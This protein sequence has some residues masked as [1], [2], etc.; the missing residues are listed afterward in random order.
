MEA[1]MNRGRLKAAEKMFLAKYPGGFNNPEMEAV[2]KKHRMEKMKAMALDFF[3]PDNFDNPEDMAV[4]MV[5]IV[6]SSS[7]V[8]VFEK[9]RFRDMMKEIP[10]E[11]KYILVSGLRLFIHGKNRDDRRTGF[12]MMTDLLSVYKLAK[13]TLMTICPVY[14][15]PDREVFIKP[16]T[17][18]GI[19]SY[20]E[21]E[22]L[23]YKPSPAFD[24]YENY[25]R[26]IEEM[27]SLVDPSL[28][29]GN[30]AF[31]GFLMMAMEMLESGE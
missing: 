2:R 20:F 7:M 8:S 10:F 14:Y 26:A 19:I 6:T 13:W 12:E 27:K 5:K 15:N 29:P 28:A 11:E 18:K 23:I 25:T 9:P 30:P 16:T 21:L 24:F 1:D 31:T 22:D 4:K 3:N 17:I